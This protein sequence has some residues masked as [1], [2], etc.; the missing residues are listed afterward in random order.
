MY[1]KD[2]ASSIKNKN[3]IDMAITFSAMNRVFEEG[4]KQ[5][6]ARKLECSFGLL[7]AVDGEDNFE[8]IHS[9]FCEWFVKNVFSAKKVLKNKVIK[10]SRA[11]SY[12]QAAK[13][14]DVALKVYVYYCN[15]PDCESAAK[16]LPMLH[17]AVDTLMMK[18]LKK[19]YPKEDI[20]AK[21]IE[22]VSKSDYVALQ[23]LVTKHI[24]D[25]FNN[26]ILPVQYDDILWYRLNRR[27]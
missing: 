7:A 6:I 22:A 21:T 9:E 24:N 26:L 10:S 19:N 3:V 20:K 14:F 11:A 4:S 15:L 13:I 23:K 27:A 18:N 17:G 25:E 16:L 5:K 12:G 1:H 8:K 2:E